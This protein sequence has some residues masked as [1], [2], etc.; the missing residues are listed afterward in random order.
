MNEMRKPLISCSKRRIG[1]WIV[2]P[3]AVHGY[4]VVRLVHVDCIIR[5]CHLIGVYGRHPVPIDFQHTITLDTFHSYYVNH[6]I[7]YHAHETVQ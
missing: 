2:K 4:R 6:Y 5:A 1:I 7:D 3:Q